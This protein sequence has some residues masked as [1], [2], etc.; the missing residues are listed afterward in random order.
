MLIYLNFDYLLHTIIHT[1]SPSIFYSII[2]VAS[3]I[4]IFVIKITQV[5]NIIKEGIYL[6]AATAGIATAS[7]H[8]WE[9]YKASKE[10]K[11]S[12]KNAEES[13][14]SKEDSPKPKEGNS[15]KK[16]YNKYSSL[17]LMIINV[18]RKDVH[19]EDDPILLFSFN[20]LILALLA[21]ISFIRIISYV[22]SVYYINKYNLY[23]KYPRYA[24]YFKY[25][26]KVRSNMLVFDIIICSVAIIIIILSCLTLLGIILL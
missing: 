1:Q 10:A 5:L 6:G 17:F 19:P 20:V 7:D 24:K 26:E 14:T 3:L 18:I 9:R 23:D 4:L 12:I 25:F 15:S 8:F 13:K 22:I 11:K 21:L 2:I 16:S